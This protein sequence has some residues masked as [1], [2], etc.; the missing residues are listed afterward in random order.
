[1]SSNWAGSALSWWSDAGVDTLVDEAPRNWLAPKSVE[2]VATPEAAPAPTLPDDLEGFR[3]W[4]V[5]GARLPLGAPAA[6]RLGPAGDPAAGLMV[7]VD[8]PAPQDVAAGQLISGAPGALFDRML[9]AMTP[10]RNRETI[11]LAPLTPLRTPTGRIESMHEKQLVEIARHHIALVKP[12]AVL[13]F[14]DACAKAL[15]GGAVAA[16]RGR[17]HDLSTPAGPV[18]TLA[19]IRP[20]KLEQQPSL[21]KIAWE[22]IQML[23]EGLA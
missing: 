1:M 2:T 20:E 8:M 16:S 6:P 9:A 22:D 10:P 14:G 17:W 7:L 5:D 11:Y 12:K 18:K 15:L 19:T 13:L 23:M 21:K 3:A 4:F